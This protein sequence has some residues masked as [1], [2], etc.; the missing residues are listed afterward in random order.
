MRIS[1]G[2]GTY[3]VGVSGGVD[4]MVLLELLRQR[5]GVKLIV[6]HFDHGIREDSHL[7][8]QFVQAAARN[9]GLAFVHHEGK[10]GATAS[11][12]EARQARYEF[13][14]RV[15]EA[16]G[17]KAIIT[18]HHQD[19]VL[20]TAVLNLM[21][22]SG[23]RGLTSLRSDDKIVRPMLDYEKS[24]IKDYATDRGIGWR[25][26]PT[27]SDE[28]Y[29]RNYVRHRILPKLSPGQRAQLV[30]L[31]QELHGIND[32]LDAHVV[33]LLHT[34]PARNVIRRRWFV[35]LPHDIAREVVYGWLRQH[36]VKDISRSTVERLVVAIKTAKPDKKVD[37]DKH[38]ELLIDRQ[39]VTLEKRSNRK[40][41]QPKE[42]A[43]Q[44]R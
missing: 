24:H 35:Q 36:G 34:Q 33:N 43:K 16:S 12:A 8:R 39:H 7:D 19:D 4:S 17:A 15:K 18:A 26:D 40:Q 25:E 38:L 20:E 27:N 23:R 21:R 1:V 5:P 11:E 30:I 31:L 32:E 37:V 13:L 44:K 10:L 41:K 29:T 14:H 6:A 42:I 2:A 3:V 9:H 22:G 28:R